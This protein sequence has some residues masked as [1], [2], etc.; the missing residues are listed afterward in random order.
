LKK[1]AILLT[2]I[3][4]LVLNGCAGMWDTPSQAARGKVNPSTLSNQDLCQAINLSYGNVQP[5]ISEF[6]LRGLDKKNSMNSFPISI[7]AIKNAKEPKIGMNLS[8]VLCIGGFF[9][10]NSHTVR[11][12]NGLIITMKYSMMRT[13][14]KINKAYLKL[15]NGI[16]TSISF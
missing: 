11:T 1:T 16:V 9:Y 7:D 3:S 12:S 14:N 10:V 13:D 2:I 6:L 15:V 5:L 4:S 8:E